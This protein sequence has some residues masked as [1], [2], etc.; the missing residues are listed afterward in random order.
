[1]PTAHKINTLGMYPR[2]S[3]LTL[4]EVGTKVTPEL[5]QP[6]ITV[7]LSL[8]CFSQRNSKG[9]VF[10]MMKRCFFPYRFRKVF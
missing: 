4:S 6:Y 10:C 1:M 2:M 5:V 9:N 7:Y 8:V 3:D